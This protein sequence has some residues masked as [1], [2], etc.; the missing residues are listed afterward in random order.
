MIVSRQNDE[1]ADEKYLQIMIRD[2]V[3]E[4]VDKWSAASVLRYQYA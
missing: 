1:T 3:Q 4:V 2:Y